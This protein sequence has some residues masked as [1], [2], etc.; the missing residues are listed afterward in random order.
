MIVV[1]DTS[2]ILNL[3][4]VGHIQLLQQ[5][6]TDVLIPPLVAQEFRQ[7]AQT[8]PRF[9]GLLLPIWLKHQTPAGIPGALRFHPF[10]DPGETQAIALAIEIHAD[11]VLV[12]EADGRAAAIS[13]G[14]RTFGALGVLLQAKRAA[15]LPQI[16]PVV[17]ALRQQAG[18]W[19]SEQLRARILREAGE[20]I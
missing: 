10:L 14:L 6:Y 15:L 5:L 12:D 19:C 17:D 13:L 9:A 11:A 3:A 20:T 8:N 16:A 4:R 7:Q 1:A 18:F 2:V